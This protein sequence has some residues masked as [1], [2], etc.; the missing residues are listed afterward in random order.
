[1]YS[2][3]ATPLSSTPSSSRPTRQASTSASPKESSEYVCPSVAGSENAGACVP[4][5]IPLEYATMIA[6]L[7]VRRVS[8]PSATASASTGRGHA[9]EARATG[10]S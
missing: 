7:P 8:C 9:G 5:G 6:S 1:M 4:S 10:A 3:V 2:A